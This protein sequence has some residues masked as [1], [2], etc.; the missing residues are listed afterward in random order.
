MRGTSGRPRAR[1]MAGKISAISPL[2]TATVMAGT[3][4]LIVQFTL[5]ASRSTAFGEHPSAFSACRSHLSAS[6]GGRRIVGREQRAPRLLVDLLLE[7]VAAAHASRLCNSR[8]ILHP[9][10]PPPPVPHN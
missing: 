10:E 8:P 3:G 2:A 9:L 1:R 6:S 7:S 4:S 5:H